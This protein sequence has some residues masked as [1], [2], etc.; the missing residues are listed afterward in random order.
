MSYTD[1]IVKPVITEKATKQQEKENKYVFKVHPG[2]SKIQIA[3][4]I[5]RLFNVKVRKVNMMKRPGKKR[6]VRYKEGLTPSWKRAIVTL[7]AGDQIEI[8]EGL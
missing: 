4:E 1:L 7:A 6:R 5:E 2:A 3:R 8:Y